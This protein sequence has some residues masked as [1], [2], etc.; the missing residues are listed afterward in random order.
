MLR[1]SPAPGLSLAV[2]R[3]KETILAR[4]YGYARLADSVRAT[5]RTVYPIASITK[6]FTAVAI[7]RLA[8]T[9]RLKLTDPIARYLPAFPEGPKPVTIKQLLGHISGLAPAPLLDGPDV[10]EQ[11]PDQRRVVDY[12]RTTPPAFLPGEHFAYSN[13][14]YYLLGAIIEVAS[15]QAYGDYLRDALLGPANLTSTGECAVGNPASATGYDAHDGTLLPNPTPLPV[16]GF[17]AGGLCSTVLDLVAWERAVGQRKAINNLSWHQMIERVE[18]NDQS[19]ASYGYGVNVGRLEKHAFI[20]HGGAT[21][22]FASQLTYFPDDDVI[23]AVL[24]NSGDALARRLADEVALLVLGVPKP[25]VKDVALTAP[26]ASLYEGDFVLQGDS[27]PMEVRFR[28]GKLE[29]TLGKGAAIRLL[30]QGSHEFAAESDPSTRL[31]FRVRS[32][33]ARVV[34][35]QTHD[36]SL[37]A[38]LVSGIGK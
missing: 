38:H 11:A 3:G 28:M 18:L 29:A 31:F 13:S 6:Q 26:R 32:G 20:G 19:R 1:R 9:K 17:A 16:P 30:Y 8:E 10:P 33:R 34:E 12:L 5:E 24:A 36:L 4:G 7:L 22:G 23:I 35:F 25:S 14:G 27:T 2:T 15:G 37:L 21:P